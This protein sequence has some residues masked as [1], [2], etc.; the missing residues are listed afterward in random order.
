M[1]TLA[2]T[3]LT[4][5]ILFIATLARSTLGFGD[6]LIAM[7]CLVMLLG[8]HTAAP[9]VALVGASI[10]LVILLRNWRNV[11]IRAAWPLILA[12]AC[13]IPLG[14]LF[15]QGVSETLVKATLGILIILFCLYNLTTPHL[16]FSTTSST[17][18]YAFGFLAGLLGGAYNTVGPLLVIYGNLQR[19][20]P[21]RFRATLQGCFFPAYGFIVVGHGFAGALTSQVLRV[22]ALS[23]PLL[24]LATV[25][26]ERLNAG[27][28]HDRFTH[29]INGILLFIGGML[30]FQAFFPSTTMPPRHSCAPPSINK[31]VTASLMQ[32]AP[33]VITP[34]LPASCTITALFSDSAQSLW[35][36]TTM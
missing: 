13:G 10:G 31:V 35:P 36:Y 24:F 25:L 32:P 19:W 22:Y 29:Y 11:D 27:M 34:V 7:P 4:L 8:I 2:L 5:L 14:L 23:L 18:A 26:G 9:L 3:G 20:S 6:A 28:P 30:C 15:L 16:A 1:S 21:A 12:S 17:P 33:P